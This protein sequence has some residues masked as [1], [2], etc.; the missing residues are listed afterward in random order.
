MTTKLHKNL[1]YKRCVLLISKKKLTGGAAAAVVV[2]EGKKINMEKILKSFMV[3]IYMYIFQLG[4]E[5]L[6]KYCNIY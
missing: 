6:R 3:E 5:M 2:V 4:V 1:L